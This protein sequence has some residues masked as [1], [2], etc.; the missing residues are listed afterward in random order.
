MTALFS[1]FPFLGRMRRQPPE[2]KYEAKPGE[3]S[4]PSGVDVGSLPDG[5]ATSASGGTVRNKDVPSPR[6][7]RGISGADSSGAHA[8]SAEHASKGQSTPS[9][10]K[11]TSDISKGAHRHG[12]QSENK[13]FSSGA[14]SVRRWKTNMHI[15]NLRTI[16]RMDEQN[17][18]TDALFFFEKAALSR[19]HLSKYMGTGKLFSSVTTVPLIMRLAA[20]KRKS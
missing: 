1:Y 4:L 17:R 18:Q 13:R 6:R 19:E 11:H 14:F 15:S 12:K 9:S 16:Q 5:A 3:T 7:G 8:S 2:A 20:F 10:R